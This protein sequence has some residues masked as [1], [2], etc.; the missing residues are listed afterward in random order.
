MAEFGFGPSS[1]E[2]EFVFGAQ[3]PGFPDKFVQKQVVD[4]WM[5]YMK[6]QGISR[7][8]CLLSE[9]ELAYYPTLPGGLLG[10]YA[11]VFGPDDV[12]WAPTLDRRLCSGEAL[13]HICYFLR[14]GML[15]GKKTVV[16]CSAGQGRTGQ[17]LAAWLIYNYSISERKALSVVEA[18][19]RSPREAV[20][21]RTAT[22]ADLLNVLAVPRELDKPD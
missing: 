7:I 21:H 10:L 16:H 3:R 18:L 6:K 11:E 19:Q 2:D 9:E 15:N 5:D 1:R 13:E 22:E 17:V 4:N 8:V 12:L 20:F 14:A